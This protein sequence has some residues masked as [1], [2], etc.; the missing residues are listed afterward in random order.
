MANASEMKYG[1]DFIE[2][3]GISPLNRIQKERY[4]ANVI[5]KVSKIKKKALLLKTDFVK[6]F[7]K[8]FLYNFICSC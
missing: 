4:I 7:R 6:S 2:D 3:S 8:N 1:K 5:S